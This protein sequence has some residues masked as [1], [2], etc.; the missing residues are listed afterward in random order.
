MTS[1]AH[2][3]RLVKTIASLCIPQSDANVTNL[4]FYASEHVTYLY[5]S[6]SEGKYEN[7]FI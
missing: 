3:R 1:S 5:I 6:I 7:R 4:K 2:R